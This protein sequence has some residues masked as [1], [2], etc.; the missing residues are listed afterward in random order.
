[1]PIRINLLAEMQ[2]LEELR[3]RDPVKRAILVGIALL[4]LMMVWVT[5]LMVKKI[6]VNGE[7]SGLESKIQLGT[8][9]YKTVLDN[10]QNLVNGRKKLLALNQLSTN[11]FLIGNVLESLQKSPVDNV[12]LIHLR[13]D[14]AYVYS[15]GTKSSTNEETGRLIPGKP[16]SDTEKIALTLNA[17]DTGPV[18][19]DAI[20][21]YQAALSRNPFLHSLIANRTND[22]RLTTSLVPQSDSDGKTFVPFTIEARLPDKTR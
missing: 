3:R 1:M 18:P 10:Q 14:Q 15:E 6:A 4:A 13:I 7:I 12:Q 20:S 5:S 9:D 8:K 22:F 11:R 2:A 19:G 21:R 16:S 17:K